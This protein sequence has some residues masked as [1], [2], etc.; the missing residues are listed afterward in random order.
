[1][2]KRFHKLYII[3]NGLHTM[4]LCMCIS[5]SVVNHD[6]LNENWCDEKSG[7]VSEK[8]ET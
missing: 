6:H 3:E 8:L 7:Q 4:C 1:M 2:L 5:G